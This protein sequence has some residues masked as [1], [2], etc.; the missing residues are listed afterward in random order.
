MATPSAWSCFG[1][2]SGVVGGILLARFAS[3]AL[4]DIGGWRT[5]YLVS[6]GLMLATS[7]LLLRVLPR[8]AFL[9]QR[10]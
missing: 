10:S 4:A 6:A 9:E 8:D 2:T 3:G 7:A 1:V 5:V